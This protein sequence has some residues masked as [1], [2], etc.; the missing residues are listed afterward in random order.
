MAFPTKDYIF[1]VAVFCRFIQVVRDL[2]TNTFLASTTQRNK[3][4]QQIFFGAFHETSKI[5]W[6]SR[7]L[8]EIVNCAILV[9]S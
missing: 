7:S 4:E 6:D 3:N 9:H 5:L 8:Y 1:Y 2:T